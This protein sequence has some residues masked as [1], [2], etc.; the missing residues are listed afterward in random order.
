M[1]VYPL[2]DLDFSDQLLE[3]HFF[4]YLA[5]VLIKPGKTGHYWKTV[6]WT[7][8]INTNKQLMKNSMCTY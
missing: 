2:S 1:C 8:N 6:D 7:K 4:F 5:L 3:T